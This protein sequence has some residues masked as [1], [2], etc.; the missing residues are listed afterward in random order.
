MT[1]GVSRASV[2]PRRPWRMISWPAAKEMRWVKP[3]IATVSPSRTRSPTASAIE[4]TFEALT[5]AGGLD[6]GD[7]VGRLGRRKNPAMLAGD[8]GDGRGEQGQRHIHLGLRHR[9][10]RR[11]ADRRPAAFED[12]EPPLEGGPLDLLGVLGG[13][14]LDADHQAPT[15]NV[16]DERRE[17][18]RERPKSG[19]CLLAARARVGDQPALE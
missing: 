14:E 5:S 7:R 8:I 6:P 19:E 10:A 17:M 4:A 9:Q 18:L 2:S 3:S 15:A 16:G 11:H 12:E 1:S 13:V